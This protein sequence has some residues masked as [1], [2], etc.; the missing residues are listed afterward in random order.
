MATGVLLIP[1]S[2]QEWL[3]GVRRAGRLIGPLTALRLLVYRD[4]V[5]SQERLKMRCLKK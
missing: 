4:T 5:Y 3:E 2:L 1:P